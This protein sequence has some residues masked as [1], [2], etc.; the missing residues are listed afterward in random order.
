MSVNSF[1]NRAKK[2]PGLSNLAGVIPPSVKS[3]LRA[4]VARATRPSKIDRLIRQTS[5][6][7]DLL[8]AM[9]YEQAFSTP[10]FQDER[11]L[12]SHGFKVYSQHDEDGIIQE[13]LKIT[14]VPA[15]F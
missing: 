6:A 9:M 10:R 5:Q 8:A 12:R 13:M 11:R 1:L 15:R 4:I 3:R 2:L 7:N 14:G